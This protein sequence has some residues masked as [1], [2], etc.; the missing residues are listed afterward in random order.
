MGFRG[1]RVELIAIKRIIE[2]KFV[3]FQNKHVGSFTKHSTI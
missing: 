1:K 3:E 2:T